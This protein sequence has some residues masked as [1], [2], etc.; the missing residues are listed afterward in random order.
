MQWLLQWNNSN[1]YILWVCVCVLKYPAWNS[2]APYC[3]LWPVR[4]YPICLHYPAND[5]IFDKTLL[6]IKYVLWFSLHILSEKFFILRT[7]RDVIK[8][9]YF[10]SCKWPVIF[11]FS[12]NQTW[13][14]F[15]D[16]RKILKYQISWK[17]VQFE[18]SC[19]MRTD[20]L[21]ETNS[22]CSQF[23]ESA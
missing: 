2:H 9:V 23:Y 12:V 4:L 13:I 1:Y 11:L 14:F 5:M 16:F 22:R 6:S 15:K 10:S 3:H 21:D 17:S 20:R 18:P 7:E 8:S 19:S